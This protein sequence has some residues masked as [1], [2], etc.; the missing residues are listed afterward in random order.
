MSP[1]SSPHLSSVRT[2]PRCPRWAAAKAGVQPA[3]R[4]DELATTHHSFLSSFSAVSQRNF[5]N[6]YAFCVL[7]QFSKKKL[8]DYQADFLKVCKILQKLNEIRKRFSTS[9]FAKILKIDPDSFVDLEKCCKM[10]IWT[11][12]SASIQPR[13]SLLKICKNL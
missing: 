10:S 7:Q 13:T 4:Q 5:A 1:S 2:A 9:F 8:Q 12:K 6:K 11:Q 3:T